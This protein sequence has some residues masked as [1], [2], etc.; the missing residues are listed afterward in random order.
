MFRLPFSFVKRQLSFFSAGV[1]DR[2]T[3]R[4]TGRRCSFGAACAAKINA[5]EPWSDHYYLS[6]IDGMRTAFAEKDFQ[7]ARILAAIGVREG[8]SKYCVGLLEL[9]IELLSHG[10]EID[11][12][13][14]VFLE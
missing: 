9:A 2:I 10:E 1:V 8:A 5:C 7:S 11:I 4:I 6:S 3:F 12:D 14:L 13:L